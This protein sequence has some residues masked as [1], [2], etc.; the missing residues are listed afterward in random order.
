MGATL[1]RRARLASGLVLFSY[2]LTHLL[3]LAVGLVSLEAMDDVLAVLY[4]FW[5]KPPATLALYGAGLVHVLLALWALWQRRS[6]RLPLP[7]AIQYVLGFAVP[8]V[9]LQH[10][11]FTRL[12]DSAFGADWGYY[13]KLVTWFWYVDP[14]D[15]ALQ[16]VLV[17]IVWV[18][19]CVGLRYWLRLKPWYER[20]QPLLFAFALLFPVVALLGYAEAGRE[21][22]TRIPREPGFIP[23]ALEGRPSDAARAVLERVVFWGRIGFLGTLGVLLAAR[24]VRRAWQAR[25]GLVRISYPDG[26]FLNVVRG[27]SVLE[28]SRLLGVPHAAICGGKGRCSTC[29]VR[30]RAAP[31][32]LPEP[33]ALEAAVL[34]RIGAAPN[35]RLACQLRPKGD[36][37]AAPLLP[38]FAH[39]REGFR[40]SGYLLGS[41]KEI[42]ILFADLRAF[43]RLAETK[44]PYDVVFVLNRYFAAMGRAIEE[45]G[46]RVDKFIGD[47]IMALFGL[48]SGAA[49]GAR[50]ALEAA[51]LMSL[52]LEELNRTLEH[53]IE[54]PLRIGIGLHIGPVIVGEMGYG[55]ATQLTAVG[56]AVNTASRVESLCKDLGVELVVSE[57]VIERA[58]VN[59]DHFP[60][61]EVEI[62]GRRQPLSVRAV[63]RACD[64]GESN[65]TLVSA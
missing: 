36:V 33:G 28:A 43:T 1:V 62:R 37:E 57:E 16:A 4:A 59:F 49:A 2:V 32:A 29:R 64:L 56:D 34:K 61:H 17:V 18:H 60:L 46:G 47:G 21:V 39:A 44:L 22:L 38:P 42:V 41:E 45:A 6:L 65:R 30:V 26:R 40:R 5:S 20:A 8:L 52:R 15:G 19:A 35:V 25:H 27:T 9:A 10:A 63:A 23:S 53:E 58:G 14:V 3:N 24:A 51:R 55:P 48:Q 31:G 12:A 50:Q 54:S 13:R 7:A 11:V